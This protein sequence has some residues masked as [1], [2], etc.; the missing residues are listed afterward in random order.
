[1]S[2]PSKLFDD[3]EI[4]FVAK[5]SMADLQRRFVELS[6]ND[7]L[8]SSMN[9]LAAYNKW[10]VEHKYLATAILYHQIANR[11]LDSLGVGFKAN[12]MDLKKGKKP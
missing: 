6:R 2:D 12:M 9:A 3:K 10:S 5:S 8:V 7:T 4:E 11:M 1:M